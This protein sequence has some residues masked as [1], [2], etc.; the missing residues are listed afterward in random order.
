M[1]QVTY[2]IRAV[3]RMTGLSV[4]TLRAWER[5]YQTVVPA[6][7]ERGRAYTDRH[8]DRLK[9]LAALVAEGHAIGSIAGLSD[10]ELQRLRRSTEGVKPAPEPGV[11][12]EPLFRAMKQYDLET[13]E[14]QFY[15]YSLLLP[16]TELIFTVVLP[17]LRETGARWAS[18][19]VAPA[20]EHL[21]SGIIRGVLG[22]L[23]RTMPRPGAPRVA[24]A[25]PAGERHELGL[26]AG[27]VLAAAAGY[28]VLYL[29]PDLPPGEIARAVQKS[30]AGVLV[31]AG[32]APD[33]DYS[34]LRTLKR[35]PE[36][37]SIWTGG[38]RSSDLTTAVGPRARRV[39][40]LE[41]LRNLLDRHAA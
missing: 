12:L 4:D 25:T 32:T 20:Q 28:S 24:F 34:E 33:V 37:V 19:V 21:V 22:G 9:Q 15:R 38:A 27:A 26:L 10:A 31:L 3:A 14:A 30:E 29:G 17:A 41:E 1:T 18:G 16:P 5:R 11:D 39:A 40:S 13:I 7:G 35:I 6:R 8:V 23:L 36:N 2:P